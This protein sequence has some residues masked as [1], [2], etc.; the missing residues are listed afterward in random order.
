MA[1]TTKSMTD[2]S[3]VTQWSFMLRW[4]DFGILVASWTQGSLVS[5]MGAGCSAATARPQSAHRMAL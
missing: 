2:D 4:S 5:F 3:A 1:F